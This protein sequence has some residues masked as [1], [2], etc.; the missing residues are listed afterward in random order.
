MNLFHEFSAS[1]RELKRITSLFE[2]VKE[3]MYSEMR[4]APGSEAE[5][6]D[7]TVSWNE[8]EGLLHEPWFDSRRSKGGACLLLKEFEVVGLVLVT[9]ACSS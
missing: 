3:K 8:A 1:T 4:G 9:V 2:S 7:V 5:K 6:L